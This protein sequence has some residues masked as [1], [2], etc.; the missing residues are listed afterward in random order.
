MVNARAWLTL[1][2]VAATVGLLTTSCGSDELNGNGGM[3]VTGGVGGG[4][5]NRGG[6]GGGGGA[7][8]RGGTGSGGAPSKSSSLGK[9]CTTDASCGSAALF[10]Y[11]QPDVP[12]GFCS[13]D[14]VDDSDCQAL[15]PG[16]LCAGDLCV[17]GCTVGSSLAAKCQGRDDFSCQLFAVD[18]GLSCA[19]DS[20][21]APAGPAY[22]CSDNACLAT[23][24]MPTC[25]N[26]TACGDGLFCDLSNG[27]CVDT[28]PTG[29]PV[30]SKCDVNAAADPCAG[31][32]IGDTD[33]TFSFCS[34]ICNLSITEA[35]GWDGTGKADAACLFVPGF[36][37][38]ADAGDSGFCGQL[39]DC[40]DDCHNKDFVCRA[41]P[42][43]EVKIFGR[44]GYCSIEGTSSNDVL[45][46]CTGTG[47][48][49][50]GGMGSGGTGS[51]GVAAGGTGSGGV[52]TGG[53]GTGGA[54][55]GGAASGGAASGGAASG[56]AASGGAASGGA[57]TGGAASGGTG[58]GGA[59]TGG[60]G[61]G[62]ASSSGG[63]SN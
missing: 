44:K 58:A 39:C 62:G 8:S 11:N 32:C 16:A 24:C 51:G 33:G 2:S 34:G 57:A 55:S 26:D 1:C 6:S 22:F 4:S 49:G 43:S 59:A 23:A 31:F 9:A 47:G 12:E 20:D 25:G 15:S 37:Q 42:A 30:G 41:L 60:T 7:S 18:P 14:C 28:E 50:S 53:I 21:C 27:L 46:Q 29:L 10:C 3:I 52:A 48:T 54:A 36:N 35:C 13:A 45:T 17:Q 63:N 19:K 61:A 56:G 40:S 38:M 5:G